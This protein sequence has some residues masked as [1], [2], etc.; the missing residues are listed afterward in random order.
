HDPPCSPGGENTAIRS[1]Q[2]DGLEM[3]LEDQRVWVEQSLAT[4]CEQIFTELTRKYKFS[5]CEFRSFELHRP[6][7]HAK[8][9][10]H[11]SS[12]G[13]GRRRFFQCRHR[14]AVYSSRY[15]SHVVLL[16]PLEI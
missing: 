4:G 12:N 11:R 1:I 14:E 15:R 10:L 8:V 9:A 7:H 6:S 2:D 5:W 3:A 13:R 16:R